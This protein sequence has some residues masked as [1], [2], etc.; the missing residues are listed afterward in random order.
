M[1]LEKEEV[2]SITQRSVE[3]STSDGET[4]AA[5]PLADPSRTKLSQRDPAITLAGCQRIV[6]IGITGSGKT[7]LA[8]ELVAA[9]VVHHVELDA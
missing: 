3:L 5:N 2:R 7:T 4:A 8:R 6:I 9:L 1:T